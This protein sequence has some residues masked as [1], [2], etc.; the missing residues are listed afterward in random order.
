MFYNLYFIGGNS[1]GFVTHR[2]V[3]SV[4]I[5]FSFQRDKPFQFAKQFSERN[6]LEHFLFLFL[7]FFCLFIFD[8]YC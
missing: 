2:K 4:S 6:L 7:L 3:C 5:G 1:T 8:K